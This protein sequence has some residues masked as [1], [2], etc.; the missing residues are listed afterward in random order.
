[1]TEIFRKNLKSLYKKL[2]GINDDLKVYDDVN[3]VILN[4]VRSNRP[5]YNIK[6]EDIITSNG[7]SYSNESMNP[8]VMTCKELVK[9]NELH[10][11][12]S[13]CYKFYE[14]FQPK[15][16]NEY[17]F[18]DKMEFDAL[19]HIKYPGFLPPWSI[20]NSEQYTKHL[21]ATNRKEDRRVIKSKKERNNLNGV[22]L[23]G[24]V[25]EI[26][27]KAEILRYKS[28]IKSLKQKGY[29]QSLAGP[30]QVIPLKNQTDEYFIIRNGRHRVAALSALGYEKIPVQLSPSSFIDETILKSG[31]ACKIGPWSETSIDSYFYILKN[32]CGE[33]HLKNLLS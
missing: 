2:I 19:K 7:I 32:R 13:S 22:N 26:K 25:S 27:C 12:D 28:L 21:V 30:I 8:F 24:P 5:L 3:I 18:N 16:A 1:M 29:D 6:M 17:F 14:Q 9:N 33:H 20:M 23:F 11:K 31:P 4:S 15:N 10:Y